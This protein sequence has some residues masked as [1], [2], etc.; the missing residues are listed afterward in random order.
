MNDLSVEHN[1]QVITLQNSGGVT[2]GG[3]LVHSW[4]LAH[5]VRINELT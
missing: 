4:V 5:A 3:D 1:S 2:G